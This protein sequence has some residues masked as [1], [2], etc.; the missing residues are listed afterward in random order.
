MHAGLHL[1]GV[2]HTTERHVL[3]P[4]VQVSARW[5]GAWSLHAGFGSCNPGPQFCFFVGSCQSTRS[6]AAFDATPSC[7]AEDINSG[8][9]GDGDVLLLSSVPP[10]QTEWLQGCL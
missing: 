8:A 3:S 7:I 1:G 6:E 9:S 2:S 5:F 10:L 4:I